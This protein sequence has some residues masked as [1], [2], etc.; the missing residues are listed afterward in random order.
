MVRNT[1]GCYDDGAAAMP[2]APTTTTPPIAIATANYAVARNH[3]HYPHLPLHHQKLASKTRHDF[4][5]ICDKA[6]TCNHTAD[7]MV[8]TR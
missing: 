5:Q 1:N 2:T 4:Y 7:T 3:Y 6:S 8:N